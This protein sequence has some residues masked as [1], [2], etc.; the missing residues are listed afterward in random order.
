MLIHS[1]RFFILIMWNDTKLL[2]HISFLFEATARGYM[3]TS[4]VPSIAFTTAMAIP[5]CLGMKLGNDTIANSLKP[6]YSSWEHEK[7]ERLK[8]QFARRAAFGNGICKLSTCER[9]MY[10]RL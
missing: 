9:T 8:R 2:S 10:T 3:V 7:E 5:I 6:I 4:A 1:E